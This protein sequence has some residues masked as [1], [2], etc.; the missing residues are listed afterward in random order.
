[1]K[2]FNTICLVLAIIAAT[3]VWAHGDHVMMDQS[4]SHGQQNQVNE[5]IYDNPSYNRGIHSYPN[6]VKP[7]PW[8]TPEILYV[9]KASGQAIYSY[10]E[11]Q[12]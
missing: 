9:D 4:N 6:Y 8:S 2:T 1:M 10:P 11:R 3:N 7:E 12:G 5:V